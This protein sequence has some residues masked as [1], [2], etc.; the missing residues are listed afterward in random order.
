[1]KTDRNL[2]IGMD[3]ARLLEF[4]RSYLAEGFPN[5]ERIGCPNTVMLRR[6]GEQPTAVDPSVTEHLGGCSPCFRQY[7][8]LLAQSKRARRGTFV[9]PNLLIRTPTFVA[10]LSL[11]VLIVGTLYA[12]LLLSHRTQTAREEANQPQIHSPKNKP[13]RIVEFSPFILDMSKVTQVRG[14][15]RQ[16]SAALKLP[17]KPLHISVYLPIGSDGGEYTVSLNRGKEHVWSGRGM[18]QMRDKQMVME[19]E[20]GLSTHEP[21]QYTLTLLSKSGLRLTQRIV[22]EEEPN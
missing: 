20:D 11:F 9:R 4:A 19:L 12:L 15:S 16:N 10:M 7:L 13:N 18:A 17:R 8:E 22:L 2:K 14:K 5:P 3:E 1:M 21:G 6:L